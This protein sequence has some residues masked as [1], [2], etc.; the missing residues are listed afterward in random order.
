MAS[1]HA[2]S[3][4]YTTKRNCQYFCHTATTRRLDSKTMCSERPSGKE[5]NRIFL[6]VRHK[7]CRMCQ[8]NQRRFQKIFTSRRSSYQFDWLETGKCRHIQSTWCTISNNNVTIWYNT[9]CICELCFPNKS[10]PAVLNRASS[11]TNDA[12]FYTSMCWLNAL[13]KESFRLYNFSLIISIRDER[14]QIQT[15][16][17]I[18]VCSLLCFR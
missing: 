9:Q 2:Q 3:E 8:T 6:T 18:H 17:N 10:W 1:A 4:F 16:T 5:I 13:R 14:E 12:R 11:N 15:N 7:Y